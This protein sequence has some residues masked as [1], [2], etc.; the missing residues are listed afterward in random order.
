VL[1]VTVSVQPAAIA[2]GIKGA[3]YEV[4]GEPASTKYKVGSGYLTAGGQRIIGE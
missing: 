3:G 4:Q 2:V 1:K